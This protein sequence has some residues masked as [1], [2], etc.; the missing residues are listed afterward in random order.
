[1]TQ[2]GLEMVRVGPFRHPI[3]LAGICWRRALERKASQ[4]ALE[5]RRLGIREAHPRQHVA[6]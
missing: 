4:I 5:A 2:K 6:T 3:S 1:M